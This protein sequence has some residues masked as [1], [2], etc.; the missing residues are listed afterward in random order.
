[1]PQT[2]HDT[3]PRPIGAIDQA[4]TGE[5]LRQC[6][7]SRE[8]LPQDQLIRFVRS[9]DGQAVPDTMCKL[10]GRGAW[11]RASRDHIEQAVRGGAFSRAFKTETQ[12]MDGLIDTIEAQLVKRC[13]GLIGMAKKSGAVVVGFDQVRAYIRGAKPGWLLEA[14]DGSAD[15]RNKVHFLARAIYDEVRVAGALSS[16]ELGMAFG[17]DSVIHGLLEAGRLA[18]SFGVSYRQLLGFRR[19]PETGWFS[20]EH[21]Q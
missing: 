8:R 2:K 7:V 1:M 10:P 14:S 17:R 15:G 11:V 5:T 6:V 16:A 13:C 9:P 21:E 20:D 18:D 4:G 12:P 3:A 19:A